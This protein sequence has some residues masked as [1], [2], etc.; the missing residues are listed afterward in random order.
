[1]NGLAGSA[2]QETA[3]ESAATGMTFPPRKIFCNEQHGFQGCQAEVMQR[4]MRTGI[5]L[6]SASGNAALLQRHSIVYGKYIP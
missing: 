6:F 5:F 2:M 3:M 4:V 1:V